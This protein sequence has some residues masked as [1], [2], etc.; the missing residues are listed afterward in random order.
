M[1]TQYAH[2]AEA[3]IQTKGS[4]LGQHI[5]VLSTHTEWGRNSKNQALNSSHG[6]AFRYANRTKKN[7]KHGL[8]YPSNRHAYPVRT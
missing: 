2:K 1:R 7:S 3:E 8:M 6:D 4:E 5:C